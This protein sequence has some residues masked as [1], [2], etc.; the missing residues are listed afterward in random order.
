MYHTK[1]E[2]IDMSTKCLKEQS[3]AMELLMWELESN[4]LNKKHE[5]RSNSIDCCSSSNLHGE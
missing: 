2:Q 5:R 1:E 4:Y 3:E